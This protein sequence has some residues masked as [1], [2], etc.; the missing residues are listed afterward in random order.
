MTPASPGGPEASPARPAPG[1]TPNILG[2]LGVALLLLL[3]FGTLG[4]AVGGAIGWYLWKE[5]AALPAILLAIAL[6]LSSGGEGIRARLPLAFRWGAL[7][8]LA[9]TILLLPFVASD[10]PARAMEP[11]ELPAQIA[12]L[13]WLAG[14]AL[15]GWRFQPS[16]RLLGPL[17]ALVVA[18][19]RL[20]VYPAMAL[21]FA[22][23]AFVVEP[24]GAIFLAPLVLG[25]VAVGMLAVLLLGAA[26]AWLAGACRCWVAPTKVIAG[27]AV[28]ALL[29]QVGVMAAV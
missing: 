25:G 2:V 13:A 17:L 22:G 4:L 16:A 1:A 11:L 12:G 3:P 15:L 9:A 10:R 27:L 20:V 7:A 28:L 21:P 5:L 8:I 23:Y 26:L 18:T 6:Y 29:L 24:A 14:I 19:S